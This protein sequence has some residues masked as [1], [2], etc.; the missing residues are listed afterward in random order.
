MI[1]SFLN[2][3]FLTIHVCLCP[4]LRAFANVN[5]KWTAIHVTKSLSLEN[6]S[7]RHH[8]TVLPT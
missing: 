1:K 2:M 5:V 3:L 8:I 6:K 7:L 4:L